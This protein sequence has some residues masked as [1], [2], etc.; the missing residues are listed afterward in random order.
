VTVAEL[1]TPPTPFAVTLATALRREGVSVGTGQVLACQRGLATLASDDPTDRYWVGRLTLVNDPADL[2]AYDRAVRSLGGELPPDVEVAT[3]P[4]PGDLTA[5]S[6]RQSAPRAGSADELR[7]GA[8]ASVRERLRHRR[9][10]AAT[11]EELAELDRALLRLQVAVPQ[12]VSRR[13]RPGRGTELD[14]ARTLDRALATDGELVDRAWRR[15]RRLPRRLVVVLDVSGSMA[16]HARALLRF[17]L[18]A[19][20]SADRTAARRVEVFAFATRLT[21]LSDALALRD[22][23][24]AIAAAAA[25]V[26]DWD[27][28]TRI[29]ASLDE[30]VRRWGRRGLLRGAVV[31]VCSDGLE[32]GDP[33]TLA[34]A[35]ARLRR[36]CHRLVWVNPL[37]GDER[38]EPSQRGMAAALPAVDL[39]VPSHD[40]ASLESLAGVLAS[41]R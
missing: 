4:A 7:A 39:L 37:A 11:P 27:G 3:P 38:F 33:A 16:P 40:L 19:R 23:D 25:H 36:S 12:R 26:V 31:V 13:T 18:A 41:V 2:A 20:R 17:A 28:G 29:G 22:P 6:D 30:L 1:A 9:F 24:A 21:R 14:L 10:D 32:R 5:A 8:V 15:R 34:A 35:V